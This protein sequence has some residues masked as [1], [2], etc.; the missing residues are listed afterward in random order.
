MPPQLF[1]DWNFTLG[2][3]FMFIVGVLI[4]AS[5][6]LITPFVQNVMGYPVLSAGFLLGTR[7]YDARLP[8]FPA[9]IPLHVR[10]SLALRDDSGLGVFD[11][12]IHAAGRLLAEARVKG[13]MPADIDAYLEALD[14]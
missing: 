10:A 3:F 5:V 14:G 2:V 4:L 13:Q 12:T 1:R 6:A 8:F 9:N 11:C 7:R